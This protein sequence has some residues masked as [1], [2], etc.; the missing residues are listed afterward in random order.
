MYAEPKRTV[1]EQPYCCLQLT[2][3]RNRHDD[4]VEATNF[5]MGRCRQIAILLGQSQ[6]Q[7]RIGST[8]YLLPITEVSAAEM[9]PYS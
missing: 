3:W 7:T 9:T 6:L 8:V 4:I 2:S 1:F 5:D